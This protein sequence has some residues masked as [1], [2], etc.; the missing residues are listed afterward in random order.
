MADQEPLLEGSPL[1]VVIVSD[2][3]H[4]REDARFSLP[5][6]VAVTFARDATRASEALES[7]QPTVVV[8]DMQ[9]GNA[10]GYALA[11]EMAESSHLRNVPIIILLERA[12]DAWLAER[13]GA[14]AHCVKPLRPGELSDTVMR[15][16]AS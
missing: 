10:G 8:V 12:Q 6:D 16:A 5:T 2:D 9:T 11:R 7:E 15:F 14:S 1:H 13:A 3:P 4:V